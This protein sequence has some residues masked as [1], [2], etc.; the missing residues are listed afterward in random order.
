V[1]DFWDFLR[2]ATMTRALGVAAELRVADA[3]DGGPRPV[4]ELAAEAGADADT[5]HRILRAL[6]SDGVFAET[7]P[8]VFT[9]TDTSR[10]LQSGEPAR[11]FARL[12]GGTWYR[13]VGDL[14]ASTVGATFPRTFGSDFWSWLAEHPEERQSFDLAMEDGKA[15]RVER[16]AGL[17][18][19]AGE[20]VVDVGGGNGSLLV[21]LT[22]RVPG[23]R[24][25]VFD[26]P[27]T[28]RD[29]EVLAARSIEFVEGSFFDS[30]PPADVYILGTVLHDWDDESAGAILRTIRSGAPSGSRVLIVDAV[31]PPGNEPHSAKW[32]DLL[33]L[34]LAGGRER[35]EAEWRA[36]LED[37]GLRIDAI[38][39]GLIQASCP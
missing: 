1:T 2:G 9:H 16:I 27:E 39:D 31:V 32:L 13:A 15:R 29:E 23:L 3:L 17:P 4:D 30:V 22:A 18:W 20:T 38:Q 8:G 5:L 21:E 19:R 7:D 33:M 37:T 12:F 14:D 24:G 35:T 11:E 34:V 25:V 36:L 28:V 26:V 6:A 10:A